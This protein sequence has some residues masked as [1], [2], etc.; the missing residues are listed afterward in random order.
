M[1]KALDTDPCFVFW[2]PGAQH[3]MDSIKL[4][5]WQLPWTMVGSSSRTLRVVLE[6]SYWNFISKHV[7]IDCRVASTY[8]RLQTT[9]KNISNIQEHTRKR[10]V[11]KCLG[12][13][14]TFEFKTLLNWFKNS[15]ESL[16]YPSSLWGGNNTPPLGK[17]SSTNDT[18]TLSRGKGSR[19]EAHH[20]T[21]YNIFHIQS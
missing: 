1:W 7:H 9:H 13:P 16:I 17:H 11:F 10:L 18:K 21:I 2:V 6:D 4:L 20:H 15:R 8:F 14:L 12:H 3:T 19:L 5:P